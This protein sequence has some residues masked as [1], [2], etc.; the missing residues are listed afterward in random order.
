MGISVKQGGSWSNVS[1]VYVRQ[2]GAWEQVAYGWVKVSGSWQQMYGD[3]CF[4]RDSKVTMADGSKKEIQDVNTHDEVLSYHIPG[5]PDDDWGGFADPDTYGYEKSVSV[6]KD[7][8]FSF[9]S[10]FY[11]INDEIKVTSEHPFLTWNLDDEVYRFVRTENIDPINH[12]LVDVNLNRVG[13][14]SIRL[15][16]DDIEVVNLMVEE[17]DI[18]IVE[19]LIVHNK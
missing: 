8:K 3:S 14:S 12:Q 18:F 10:D 19:D 2:S 15:L 13:I 5:L 9:R 11:I 4:A 6:V 17:E 7:V 16:G 1:D